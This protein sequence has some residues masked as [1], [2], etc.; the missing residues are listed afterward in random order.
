MLITFRQGGLWSL[1]TPAIPTPK[2]TQGSGN[3]PR[4]LGAEGHWVTAQCGNLIWALEPPPCTRKSHSLHQCHSGQ[5]SPFSYA[6]IGKFWCFLQGRVQGP[7]LLGPFPT[8]GSFQVSQ[9]FTSGP[10]QNNQFLI[11]GST[12]M[13]SQDELLEATLPG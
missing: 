4:G 9:L 2:H 12:A 10:H 7:L 5:K 1:S 3:C 13:A 6:S 11:L 8:S